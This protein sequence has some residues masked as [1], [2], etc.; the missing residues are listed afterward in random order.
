M[1][2]GETT[3]GIVSMG[4]LTYF[5]FYVYCCRKKPEESPSDEYV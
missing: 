1:D 3:L 5:A 2:S 4:L